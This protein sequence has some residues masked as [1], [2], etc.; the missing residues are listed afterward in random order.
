MV[1]IEVTN[2]GN[3]WHR[4]LDCVLDAERLDDIGRGLD[5]WETAKQK[6]EQ[7][8]SESWRLRR[9]GKGMRQPTAVCDAKRTTGKDVMREVTK[10]SV[11]G[12]DEECAERLD[13]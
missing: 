2:I 3:G 11:K 5:R 13:L 1:S 9:R 10:Y 4:H 6:H 7:P 12:S 8:S